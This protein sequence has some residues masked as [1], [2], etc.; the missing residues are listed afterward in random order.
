M[1]AANPRRRLE[2]L[3]HRLTDTQGLR[4]RL[5]DVQAELD[6]YRAQVDEHFERTSDLFQEVTQKYRDLHDHL[7]QGA[8]GLTRGTR[9]LTSVE[10]PEKTLLPAQSPPDTVAEPEVDRPETV[11]A[12]DQQSTPPDASKSDTVTEED[13][14]TASRVV[15]EQEA[16]KP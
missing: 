12:S 9:Q 1:Q 5:A 11:R 4:R 16:L 6:T 13:E 2:L 7:A 8:T 3:R 15:R 10:L 14:A